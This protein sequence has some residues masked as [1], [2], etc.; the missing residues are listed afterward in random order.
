MF[1][2]IGDGLSKKQQ[3]IN[4]QK[5]KQLVVKEVINEVINDF[6]GSN[7]IK[8][9]WTT[10]YNQEEKQLLIETKSKTLASEL[11]LRV[12]EIN[13]LLHQKGVYLKQLII[14]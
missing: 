10:S 6:L 2:S 9:F 5:S 11:L 4:N 13:T 7:N 12:G 1:R 14:R 3:S 8:L